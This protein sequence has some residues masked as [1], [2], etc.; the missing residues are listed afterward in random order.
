VTEAR[1][2]VNSDRAPIAE[3]R[4][5]VYIDPVEKAYWVD[6]VYMAAICDADANTEDRYFFVLWF[7]D[8]ISSVRRAEVTNG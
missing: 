7:E 3:R 5:K 6:A 2:A 4:W 1:G 8:L